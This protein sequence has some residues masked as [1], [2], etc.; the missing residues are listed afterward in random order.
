LLRNRTAASALLGEDH[1]LVDVLGRL[2]TVVER[3]LVVAVVHALGVILW[4]DGVSLG[5]PLAVGAVVV[6]IVLGCRLAALLQSRRQVCLGV[7]V[8]GGERLALAAVAQERRRLS[9]ARHRAGLARAIEG[10]AGAAE[11]LGDQPLSARPLVDLRAARLVVPQLYELARLLR[12]E[13]CSLRGVALSEQLLFGPASVLYGSD[14]ELLRRE[15]GR[16]SYLLSE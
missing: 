11:R 13:I 8:G 4:W 6:G 2:E 9:S 14:P 5:A 1:P 3:L 7:I 12:R 10:V 16:A 15:L